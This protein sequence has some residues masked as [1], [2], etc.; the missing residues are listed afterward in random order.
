MTLKS[1]ISRMLAGCALAAALTVTPAHATSLQT[2]GWLAPPPD[3]FT[4]HRG[5]IAQNVHAG[6]FTGV[7]GGTTNIVFWCFDLDHF[8]SL[9]GTYDYQAIALTGALA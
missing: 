5:A 1:L 4:V 2:T 6:G 8:F 3:A 7:W 9:G